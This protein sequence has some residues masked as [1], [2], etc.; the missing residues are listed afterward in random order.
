MKR[1]I[2]VPSGAGVEEV[3]EVVVEALVIMDMEIQDHLRAI[4]DSTKT[5]ISAPIELGRVMLLV[6][7]V[8]KYF[9]TTSVSFHLYPFIYFIQKLLNT[10][11]KVKEEEEGED[12]HGH[13]EATAMHLSHL[14]ADHPHVEEV[15]V[16]PLNLS[17]AFTKTA[18]RLN[19]KI[20]FFF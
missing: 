16:E 10:E 17:T 15:V 6:S 20:G 2:G 19:K 8:N 3:V 9:H 14:P 13:L 12:S 7:L 4:E 18:P 11:A 5:V 1:S